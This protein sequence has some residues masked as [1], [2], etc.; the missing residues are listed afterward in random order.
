[1]IKTFDTQLNF[2]I[3]GHMCAKMYFVKI[4]HNGWQTHLSKIPSLNEIC[5]SKFYSNFASSCV[6]LDHVM[7]RTVSDERNNDQCSG[8]CLIYIN[9]T[10]FR[11]TSLDSKHKTKTK[12]YAFV[13]ND[14]VQENNWT[15]VFCFWWERFIGSWY[16]ENGM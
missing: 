5:V 11:V 4:L 12:F 15:V 3:F 10:Q 7:V 14:W 9:I 2:L 1:M 13:M 16:W 8:Q 6:T